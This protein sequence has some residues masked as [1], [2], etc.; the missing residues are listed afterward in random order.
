VRCDAA[1][2]PGRPSVSCAGASGV[3]EMGGGFLAAAALEVGDL[4]ALEA[5][6]V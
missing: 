5:D 6:D 1:V 3:V 2:R 4:L